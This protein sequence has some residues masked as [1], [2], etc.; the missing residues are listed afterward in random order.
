MAPIQLS[1]ACLVD[2]CKVLVDLLD[3]AARSWDNS[4]AAQT[5]QEGLNLVDRKF[6]RKGEREK[7][8]R[9]TIILQLLHVEGKTMLFCIVLAF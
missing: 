1:L 8:H 4:A 7:Q 9:A 5:Y 6:C 3:A 2:G